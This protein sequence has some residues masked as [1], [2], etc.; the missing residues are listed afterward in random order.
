MKKKQAIDGELLSCMEACRAEPDL[1]FKTFL[2]VKEGHIWSKMTEIGRSVVGNRKTVVKAG[3]SV[4]KTYCAARLA[5]WFLF[6]HYPSTVITTAPSHNQVEG[7]LWRQIRT[8][9]EHS[10]VELGGKLTL[11]QLDLASDWFAIGFSTIAD[12]VTQQATRFQ[13]W[14]NE[15]VFV[16]FDEA[17]GVLPQIWQ[18]AESL[19]IT[20]HC[21]FLAIGNPTSAVGEFVNCFDNPEYNGITISVLD[22]PNYLDGKDVIPGVA[23]RQYEQMMREKYGVDSPIYQSRV[24]GQIPEYAEGVIYSREMADVKRK[25]RIGRDVSY[26]PAHLV[27][28]AWDIGS[29]LGGPTNAIWFVQ[30][31]GTELRLIDFICDVNRGLDF[32]AREIKG[33]PYVYGGHFGGPDLNM[34]SSQTGLTTVEFSR[35]LG[36]PL[37]PVRPHRV[38]DGILAVRSILNRCWFDKKC[39]VGVEAL[40][41]YH[42]KKNDSLSTLDKPVYHSE[43]AHDW[44]CFVGDT[45]IATERGQ[46]PISEVTTDDRV[47]TPTG[48]KRVLW[49]G[50]TRKASCLLEL[51]TSSGKK[52]ICTPEH[53]I[54]SNNSFKTADALRHNSILFKN[55]ILRNMLWKMLWSSTDTSLGFKEVIT[56]GLGQ[57]RFIKPYGSIIMVLFRRVARYITLMA[58]RGI[59]MSPIYSVC[60]SV[61]MTYCMGAESSASGSAVRQTLTRSSL[62]KVKQRNG[63]QAPK[64]NNFILRW[65]GIVGSIVTGSLRNVPFAVKNI[66]HLTPI[67]RCT[68]RTTVE[69]PIGGAKARTIPSVCALF[70]GLFLR[71]INTVLPERVVRIVPL[72]YEAKSKDVYD[73]TVEND[74][75]YYAEGILVSNSHPADSF[76]HLAQAY[77]QGLI[78]PRFDVEDEQFDQRRA[79]SYAVET[80]A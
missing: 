25:G 63:M 65:A 59:T 46:I 35:Q 10:R 47:L 68:V 57:K 62:S 13:G 60:P 38:E 29:K 7:V 32:F 21:R 67:V 41:Q 42:R 19:L 5:L 27:Y 74:H 4:S 71:L 73:L 34:A 77:R 75:C 18:A 36:I 3:H 8:A 51:W 28:T 11:T 58:T 22:T 16:L 37:L 79:M 39:R 6:C 48:Y 50:K 20:G 14:H 45:K 49:S 61:S 80:L 26:D 66:K 72:N 23:G 55:T 33:R 24:L 43:P 54:F 2:D 52:L 76:R 69:R 44:S 70:A 9:W 53:E 64:V 30:L 15:Y 56:L 78:R 12:T 40:C 1:F 17:A 31:V